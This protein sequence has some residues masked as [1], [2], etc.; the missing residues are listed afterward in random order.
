MGWSG[1][2]TACGGQHDICALQSREGMSSGR[3]PLR[4][5]QAG[6]AGLK[7]TGL[8]ASLSGCAPVLCVCKTGT[9][10]KQATSRWLP[11]DIDCPKSG[12]RKAARPH[13]LH[14]L[15]AARHQHCKGSGSEV[16]DAGRAVG[17]RGC[18][19]MF[20]GLRLGWQPLAVLKQTGFK[21]FLR[22]WGSAMSPD[23]PPETS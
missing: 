6:P 15:P 10:N 2:V 16:R 13:P 19:S 8:I 12:W 21:Q 5:P 22:G 17:H 1:G 3:G 9:G 18:P 14:G 7:A 11:Q 23:S 20:G 4:Y